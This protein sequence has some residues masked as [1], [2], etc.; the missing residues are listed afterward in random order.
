MPNEGDETKYSANAN[1]LACLL[2]CLRTHSMPN[3]NATHDGQTPLSS[4]LKKS[5]SAEASVLKFQK[6]QP[7]AC[8]SLTSIWARM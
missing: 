2:A 4:S 6:I 7:A 3:A 8:F 5:H 1:A